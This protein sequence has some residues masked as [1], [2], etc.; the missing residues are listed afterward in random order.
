VKSD[1][2]FESDVSFAHRLGDTPLPIGRQVLQVTGYDDMGRAT[3]VDLTVNIAQGAP[4]PEPNRVANALPSL[5]AGESLATSSGI[6][7]AVV[8]TAVPERGEVDIV[9]GDWPFNVALSEGA[10]Q[11]ERVPIGAMI[12]L[13]QA[14]TAVV[15]GVGFQPET[16]VDIWLFS[17]PTL[18][19]S[20]GVA[21]DGTFTG[22]VYLDARFVVVGGHTL[23]L[24]GV[25]ADGYVKAANVGV[26][27][28]E[29]P[30]FT[31]TSAF[32]LMGWLA[33]GLLFVAFVIFLVAAIRRNES[34]RTR[35]VTV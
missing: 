14:E 31:A 9:S 32:A 4:N 12:T 7:E 34:R 35:P 25:A 3:V 1:G 13:V 24:Q 16:R 28:N 19:G 23:Q 5:G 11:V 18:L 27:V 22:E 17:E 10:G 26:V 6:P 20:V 33:G 2:T 30:V 21:A 29:A 8:V 15:S